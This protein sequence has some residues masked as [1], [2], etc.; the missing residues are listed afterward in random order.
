MSPPKQYSLE[1]GK[2][3]LEI[4]GIERERLTQFCSQVFISSLFSVLCKNIFR[5]F[6]NCLAF[7]NRYLS[8]E[9]ERFLLVC[10]IGLLMSLYLETSR[11]LECITSTSPEDMLCSLWLPSLI[12]FSGDCGLN[13][14]SSRFNRDNVMSSAVLTLCEWTNIPCLFLQRK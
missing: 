8:N 13:G 1:S 14:L 3:S 7:K 5:P 2:I 6:A 10:F 4:L 12:F 9:T 11:S